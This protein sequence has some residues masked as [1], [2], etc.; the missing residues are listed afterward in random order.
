[1]RES[2]GDEKY[3]RSRASYDL[4]KLRCKA[5]LRKVPQ[6]RRYEIDSASALRAI[7]ALLLL[8]ERIIRPLVSAASRPTLPAQPRRI[9]PLDL[10]DLV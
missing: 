4:R 5:L 2:L 10:G 7:A 9:S 8:R 6:S 3:S 1:V